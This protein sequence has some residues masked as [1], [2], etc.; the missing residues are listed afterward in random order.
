MYLYKH[1]PRRAIERLILRIVGDLFDPWYIFNEK[2]RGWVILDDLL[3]EV[4]ILDCAL[5]C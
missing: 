4:A 1:G 2:I 3:H 5:V